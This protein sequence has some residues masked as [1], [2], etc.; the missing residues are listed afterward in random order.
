MR[1]EGCHVRIT[2]LAVVVVQTFKDGAH[3]EDLQAGLSRRRDPD[4]RRDRALIQSTPDEDAQAML[5]FGIGAKLFGRI[6]G[7][8]ANEQ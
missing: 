1:A 8:W 7:W 3:V 2:P 4:L 5:A 6:G